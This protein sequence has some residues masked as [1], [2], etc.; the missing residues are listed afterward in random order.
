M[1]PELEALLHAEFDRHNCEPAERAKLQAVFEQ[2]L[3]AALARSPGTSR[4]EFLEALRPRVIEFR[5]SQRKNTA[6]PPKA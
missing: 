6:L 4:E 3:Q 5:R 2:L 1:S